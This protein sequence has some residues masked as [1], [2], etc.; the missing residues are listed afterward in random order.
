MS[1]AQNRPQKRAGTK[2]PE[3]Q[4]GQGH[5][6]PA[7]SDPQGLWAQAVLW[8]AGHK[9]PIGLVL[10][11]EPLLVT[12]KFCPLETCSEITRNKR[13]YVQGRSR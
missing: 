8:S 10:K 1:D 3:R 11:E 13:K 4:G 5:S 12:V 6:C 7:W 2:W 9:I